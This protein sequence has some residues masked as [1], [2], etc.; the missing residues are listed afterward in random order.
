MHVRD[1]ISVFVSDSD[2]RHHA[3]FSAVASNGLEHIDRQVHNNAPVTFSQYR[4]R[5]IDTDGSV[6]YTSVIEVSAAGTSVATSLALPS[7]HPV[8]ANSTATV[9]VSLSLPAQCRIHIIDVLGRVVQSSASRELPGDE[10]SFSLDARGLQ[11]S[12]YML[13]LEGDGMRMSR[14]FVIAK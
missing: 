13:L 9:R 1:Q 10:S 7:P 8:L 3:F 11:S 14:R 6:A 4:L 12:A 2:R 5:Q